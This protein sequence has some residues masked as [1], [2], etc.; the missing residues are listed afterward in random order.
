MAKVI[1]L[2][3]WMRDKRHKWTESEV[4]NAKS[5]KPQPGKRIVLDIMTESITEMKLAVARELQK[6]LPKLDYY[7]VVAVVEREDG[8][9]GYRVV[10]KTTT[11]VL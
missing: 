4:I 7:Y 3:L 11:V 9:I 6:W 1:Q 8:T 5:Q 2:H 10:V